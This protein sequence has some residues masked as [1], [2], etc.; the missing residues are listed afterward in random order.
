MRLWQPCVQGVGRNS[1][2]IRVRR[3]P[4]GEALETVF[5]GGGGWVVGALWRRRSCR[6][7]FLVEPGGLLHTPEDE[8]LSLIPPASS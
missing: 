1:D 8:P 2:K 5:P 6:L 3:L 4:G 7:R